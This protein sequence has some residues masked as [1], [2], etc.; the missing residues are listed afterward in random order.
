MIEPGADFGLVGPAYQAPML[1][2]DAENCINWYLEVAEVGNAKEPVALLGTPGLNPVYTPT[3][4][5]IVRGAWVLP[6]GTQALWVIGT[7]VILQSLSV[8]A[9]QNSIAQFT[10]TQ[11]GTLLTN[12]G[13][14]S[15]ADNGPL[16]GSKGGYAILVDG[17]YGYFYRLA[18]AGTFTFTAGTT[19][20]SAVLSLPGTLPT[21]LIVSTSVTI[22]DSGAALGALNYIVSI[23]YNTPAI[24]VVGAATAT[25][26]SDTV[27]LNIPQFGQLNDPG[28]LG[29]N[30]VAFIEGWLILNQPNSRTFY[31]TGPVPYTLM[32]P[33]S[34][35]ALKDSST[36]NLVTL[37]ENNRELWLIG[38]RT[39]E[40]W[41]NSGGANFAFSRIP[42]VGPQIG[43]AA[44]D[45]I[46]RMGT[47]LVWLARNEQGENIVV[48]T[49]QYNW[50]RIS[51]HGV[52]HAISTYPYVA[53]AV[54]FAYEEEGHLFYMLTFPT[55]DV[56]WVYDATASAHLGKPTWHQRA[57]FDV[58]GGAWHRHRANCFVNIQDLRLVGDY[59]SGQ[60]HQMSR[61]F[62][63][64][65][66]NVL[67]AQRRTPHIWSRQNRERIFHS[68]L[69]VEFTPGVGLSIGQ[70]SNPQ[71]MLRWS[72]DGGFTW[73]NEHWATIGAIGMTRNRAI[74]R[75]LGRS[76]DRVYEVNFTDP[77]PRDIIGATLYGE[78]KEQEEA[79]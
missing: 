46:A 11:V 35:F 14:V 69:Q 3:N 44:Q 36:D 18:G 20:G 78:G 4:P 79:A 70:G 23:D 57:S 17:T 66:G 77:T 50:Q 34:F 64:D 8:P 53:D 25:V 31:T 22:T 60:I 48:K 47:D 63:T 71:C 67:K 10:Y 21:G 37:S 45:S 1:L 40:V 61:K 51:N 65:A 29:A 15:I 5:A 9:T 2:Q 72:N 49:A 52:E 7:A 13:P 68:Q 24:T 28:F 19:N 39:S 58:T 55:A 75:R 33:G 43:C 42:G 56:T 73:S 76:R 12:N 41:Y 26:P 30:Q 59:Q 6:G 54:G 62:Y 27:T 32:F 16:F 38:E 74:W